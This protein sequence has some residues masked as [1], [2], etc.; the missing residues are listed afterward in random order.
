MKKRTSAIIFELLPI[1][2][3]IIAY[4]T[5]FVI[6]KESILTLVIS[7][8]AI[9]VAFNGYIFYLLFRK[10]AKEDMLIKVLSFL[11]IASSLTIIIFYIVIYHM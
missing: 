7:A 3:A 10:M 6:E 8:I 2:S 11:D 1:I 4:F 9:V 5:T